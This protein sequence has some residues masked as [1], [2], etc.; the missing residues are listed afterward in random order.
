MIYLGVSLV[1]YSSAEEWGWPRETSVALKNCLAYACL[2]AIEI[3][4]SG[5]MV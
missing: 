4:M 2:A 3:E 1:A 5:E